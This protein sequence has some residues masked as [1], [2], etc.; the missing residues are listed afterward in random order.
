[1]EIDPAHTGPVDVTITLN[2]VRTLQSLTV[3]AALPGQHLGPLPAPL[4]AGSTPSQFED[5][6][7][8]LP[9]PGRWQFELTLRTSQFDSVVTDVTVPI[10]VAR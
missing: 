1:M 6:G 8:D 9:L 2:G 10:Q 7:L 4:R 3:T 5:H